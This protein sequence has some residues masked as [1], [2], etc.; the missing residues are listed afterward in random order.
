[1]AAATSSVA[2]GE[3]FY[4]HCNS[5]WLDDPDIEI[6]ADYSKWGSFTMLVDDSL[7]NQIALLE[8]VGAK[9][10][11]DGLSVDEQTLRHV[12]NASMRRFDDW[13]AGR[14]DCAAIHAELEQ[15]KE[16]LSADSG[17]AGLARYFARAQ[18][19]GISIPLGFDKEA[20]LE[21]ADNIILDFSPS[22]LSLPSRDYYLDEKF[23]EK[24]GWF[25]DH[26]DK[27]A[28][29]V[30]RD[31]VASD[32]R[33]RV[34]RFETKMAKIKMSPDQSRQ[35]DQYFTI[36]TLDDL[37]DNINDLKHL[38]AKDGNYDTKHATEADDEDAAMLNSKDATVAEADRARIKAF[39][40][41]FQDELGLRKAMA[42][43]FAE[44][45]PDG[46]AAATYR[47]MVFDGDYMRRVFSLLFREGNRED[48]LAYLQYKV[49]S[50]GSNFATK[51]LNEEYFDMFARKLRGQKEQKTPKKR[52][53]AL[54]NAWVDELLGKIYVAHHFSADD[55]ANVKGMVGEVLEVMKQS[56]HS[57]DWLTAP[58]KEKALQK[59][60]K[61]VVKIGYPD[62]W[63][64]YSP[65]KIEADDSL[66]VMEQKVNAFEHQDEFLSKLNTKKDRTKWEM[67]P[68]TVNAYFHPLNNEIV[69]PSAIIQPPFFHKSLDTL[70]FEVED[71]ARASPHVLTALNLGG[72]GAVIAHE[73]THGYDDQ[74]RKFDQDGNSKD[75]WQPE[76][77]ELFTAKT[78][79]MAEQ[80]GKY[81]FVDS[82]GTEHAQNPDLTMGENLADLGGMSLAYQALIK[83]IRSANVTADSAEEHALV[84][85]FFQNWACIWKEKSSEADR[86]SQLATD[87]HAP[88]DFR[89]NL[90]KNI[91][92]FYTAFEVKEGEAMFV[93]PDKRVRMW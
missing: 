91:D 77:A 60:A 52:T 62:K 92:A 29:L 89:G 90:V 14:G 1:M 12:W 36:T 10:A 86:V 69:F 49:I 43:N 59:L 24:R 88:T 18:R 79:L 66:F 74:G 7:K 71:A 78:K 82:K 9:P 8:A 30:G 26:L 47:M 64:D 75:W 65:L 39:L 17:D 25:R 37:V 72:I 55:K 35:F 44:H 63:R 41:V 22:G 13:E 76:D 38:A 11:G 46:E 53:V 33:D 15:L 67:S 6:P 16:H 80:A 40:D 85:V 70:T 51:A 83:R 23:E 45:Y 50:S 73:I 2:A 61:F 5:A 3:D 56:I 4:R 32:F 48:I 68:Q 34:L 31:H 42:A 19:V 57:N 28:D 54:I 27:V 93:A 81:V 58:T 87:P 20:N 21:D 84:R